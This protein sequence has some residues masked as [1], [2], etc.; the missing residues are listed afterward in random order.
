MCPILLNVFFYNKINNFL[1]APLSYHTRHWAHKTHE[2]P[3][4]VRLWRRHCRK[5]VQ[6]ASTRASYRL[7]CFLCVSGSG[8]HLGTGRCVREEGQHHKSYVLYQRAL[9]AT[10]L[11]TLV[12][13]SV[14]CWFRLTSRWHQSG[15]RED[16]IRDHQQTARHK[17]RP[18]RLWELYVCPFQCKPRQCLGP[19]VKW[20]VLL[21]FISLPP[22]PQVFYWGDGWREIVENWVIMRK[23]SVWKQKVLKTGINNNNP[24]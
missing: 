14:R 2:R 1:L 5:M 12:P 23:Q 22:P 21:V 20:W 18:H 8:E 17:G 13:R 7:L 11:R 15:N 3:H 16:R 10:W 6:I 24:L 19:R 9:H 4:T